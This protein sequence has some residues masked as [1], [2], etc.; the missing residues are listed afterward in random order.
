[1]INKWLI[2]GVFL[3]CV[4]C[5]SVAGAQSAGLIFERDPKTQ[6]L[7]QR[8]NQQQHISRGYPA[9]VTQPQAAAKQNPTR[10]QFLTS[11]QSSYAAT[12]DLVERNL[13]ANPGAQ[14]SQYLGYNNRNIESTYFICRYEAVRTEPPGNPGR[15][16]IRKIQIRQ[17][18]FEICMNREG[19][20]RKGRA[21]MLDLSMASFND[22]WYGW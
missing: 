22:W 5:S 21:P 9:Q 4:A 18:V 16:P 1:M 10:E 2:L 19:F 8:L 3:L 15:D 6:Q 20:F 7:Q 11:L 17:S 14:P 13:Q 12:P